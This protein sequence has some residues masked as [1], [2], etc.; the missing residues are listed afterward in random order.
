MN[1]SRALLHYRHVADL[2]HLEARQIVGGYIVRVARPRK[3]SYTQEEIQLFLQKMAELF[4]KRNNNTLNILAPQGFASAAIRDCALSQDRQSS[5]LESHTTIAPDQPLLLGSTPAETQRVLLS[6][7]KLFSIV[8]QK[9]PYWWLFPL[10]FALFPVA[11][12]SIFLVSMMK[13]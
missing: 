2:G 10:S 12:I 1:E 4:S 7:A 9:Y 6:D 5:V 3:L 11:N 13:R 8:S